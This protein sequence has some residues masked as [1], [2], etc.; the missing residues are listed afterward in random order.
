MAK[1][2]GDVIANITNAIGIKPCES[3]NKRKE[4]LN[5]WFPFNKPKE[6]TE[7]ESEFLQYFFEWYNGLP[8]PIEKVKDIEQAEQIWLR[9]FNVKTDSCKS[10]GSHYQNAFIKDLKKIYENTL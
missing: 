2:L 10:C 9:V 7:S 8:I 3:C 5:T 6:L 1:G 4:A